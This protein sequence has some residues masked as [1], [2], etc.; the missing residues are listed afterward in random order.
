MKSKLKGWIG[1]KKSAFY[2]WF[3]LNKKTYFRFHN[4][5]LPS[6]NGTTQIDHLIVSKYGLFI[7]E[8]KNRKG[9]IFGS[10]DQQNWTQVIFDQKYSFQ[11]PLRQT[12][13]QKKVLK[14]FLN[15]NEDEIKTV[16]FF[17]GR[18]TFKTPMPENV[19]KSRLGRYIKNNRHI[20]VT[21]NEVDR[22]VNDLNQYISGSNLKNID[23]IESLTL[24]HNSNTVCPKCGGGLVVRTA[25]K[26]QSSGN[27]FLGCK[28]YPKCKF[29]KK[30]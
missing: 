16:I 17:N 15:I 20:I 4:I 6:N 5:I 10:T 26:G 8:T 19:I 30:I 22:I 25:R 9:W 18:C 24:R 11:N 27:R 14:E 3:S 1:E 12:F 23:H 13:R 28:N 29:T 2:M 21:Q 7:I